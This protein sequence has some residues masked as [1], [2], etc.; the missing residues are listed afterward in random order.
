MEQKK[1]MEF[2]SV[3]PVMLPELSDFKFL[4]QDDDMLPMR[5]RT[6]KRQVH[7]LFR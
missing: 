1:R 7:T 2:D 3:R 6:C 5:R 4:G